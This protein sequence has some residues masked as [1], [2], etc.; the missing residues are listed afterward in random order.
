MDEKDSTALPASSEPHLAEPAE[1]AVCPGF[2][3][4]WSL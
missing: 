2:P 3:E 1:K 4:L